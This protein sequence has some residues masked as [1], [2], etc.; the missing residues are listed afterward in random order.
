MFAR[1]N[2]RHDTA[3]AGV[4]I[5]LAGDDIGA[6]LP[7]IRNDRRRSL[8]A[9]GL[10]PKNDHGSIIP[11]GLASPLQPCVAPKVTLSRLQRKTTGRLPCVVQ[12]KVNLSAQTPDKM[13]ESRFPP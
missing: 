12:Q 9:T 11:P 4:Q 7:A 2:L 3:I 8:I 6:N 5:R 13:F 1:G 10:D